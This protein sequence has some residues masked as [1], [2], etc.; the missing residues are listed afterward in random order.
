MDVTTFLTEL[1]RID[2]TPGNEEAAVVRVA[3]EMERQGFDRVTIDAH[4]NLVG[5]IGP[6]TGRTLVL[7]AHV[8][9]VPVYHA[10]RWG[11]DPFGGAIVDGKLYGRG[12]A[13]MKGAVAALVQA[14][15]AVKRSGAALHGCALVVVSIA[16][17]M[18]EGATLARTFDGRSVD[19][20]V[21]GEATGLAVATAQRGRAKIQVE[22]AGRSVHAAAASEGVNAV[23]IMLRLA[24]RVSELHS[25]SHPLLGC[26]DI[27]LIDIRSEPYPSISTI[28][29]YCIAHFDV[30]FLPGE[31]RESVLALFSELIPEGIDADVR[32]TPAN[33]VSY[34]GENFELEDIALAWETARSD[35]LVVKAARATGTELSTYPFCTNGSYFAGERGI[36]TIGYGP[37]SPQ[38]AHIENEFIRVT[39]LFAAVDGYA[40][41]MTAL[42][43]D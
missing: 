25:A 11:H 38:Q 12:T 10:D 24:A 8:D 1:V 27:N 42:L 13:D 23:D 21:I 43:A 33:F 16:E 37:G 36:P 6:D 19:W 41:I 15:G 7:D 14:G 17:E 26:R 18:R 35:E 20:C 4:G 29:D 32:I 39:E 30:R 2:S 3:Q 9:T 28:P 5:Q 22:V 31:S 40:A 34:V